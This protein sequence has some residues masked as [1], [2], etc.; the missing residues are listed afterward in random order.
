M[1][2]DEKTIKVALKIIKQR[3]LKELGVDIEKLTFED[4]AIKVY[5]LEQTVND[6]GAQTKKKKFTLKRFIP[7]VFQR[8]KFP[9]K[10][11]K[12]LKALASGKPVSR[13]DLERA[14]GSDNIKSLVKD[15]N[16]RLLSYEADPKS[17]KNR[18][19][20]IKGCRDLKL[21]DHYRLVISTEFL[22]PVTQN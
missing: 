10:E 16:K 14:T 11:A 3:Y 2:Y 18:T 17:K 4:L 21:K 20:Y 7:I 9:K 19:L 12:L 1:E 5:E 22:Q 8:F 13:W 6:L 15:T